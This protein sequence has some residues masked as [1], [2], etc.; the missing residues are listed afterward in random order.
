MLECQCFCPRLPQVLG[1]YAAAASAWGARGAP[2][3]RPPGA[4]EVPVLELCSGAPSQG[5]EIPV[6]GTR[7]TV[8]L[9]LTVFHPP[10]PATDKVRLKV[11]EHLR[12]RR[13]SK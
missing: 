10:Q 9:R 4:A 7:R 3:R 13:L 1:I 5:L 8:P 2:R 6:P 12:Y 11:I